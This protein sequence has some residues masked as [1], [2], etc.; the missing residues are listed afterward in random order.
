M[1]IPKTAGTSITKVID[2]H[3]C[4]DDIFP[5]QLPADV[6]EGVRNLALPKPIADYR[7]FRGHFDWTVF[8]EF[9]ALIAPVRPFSFI[10]EPAARQISMYHHRRRATLDE[11]KSDPT[12]LKNS[13]IAKEK[14]LRDNL[15]A[16]SLGRNQL[17][18]FFIGG[19]KMPDDEAVDLAFE[20]LK[21]LTVFGLAEATSESVILM[22]RA[23]G[24]QHVGPVPFLNTDSGKREP[25]TAEEVELLCE[26]T[27]LDRAFY[28]K[29]QDL[30]WE[31]VDALCAAAPDL[32][33]RTLPA[34]LNMNDVTPGVGWHSQEG[35]PAAGNPLVWRWTGPGCHSR[36]DLLLDR[37]QELRIEVAVLN[38]ISPEIHKTLQFSVNGQVLPTDQREAEAGGLIYGMDVPL[39][40]AGRNGKLV[41]LGIHVAH[42]RSFHELSLH[43]D[44]RPFGAAIYGIDILPRAISPMERAKRWLTPA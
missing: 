35:G 5:Y 14:S 42:T 27:T 18:K 41:R 12:A 28:R 8:K 9:E 25:L 23:F 40:V 38:I 6:S 21:N 26:T 19:Q 44:H 11:L 33:V 7:L 43:D 22:N 1:H 34:S 37:V 16:G 24:W 20:R 39:A 15:L 29:A 13:I 30:F 31:R 36:I 3:Y 2:Q 4:T 17:V 10:R 32:P